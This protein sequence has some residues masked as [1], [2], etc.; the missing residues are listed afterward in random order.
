MDFSVPLATLAPITASFPDVTMPR[1]PAVEAFLQR[2]ITNE[3]Q[4][5]A[6]RAMH[7]FGRELKHRLNICRGPPGSGKSWVSCL[8]K[9]Y[10]LEKWAVFLATATKQCSRGSK[11]QEAARGVEDTFPLASTPSLPLQSPL[12]N[13]G[14]KWFVGYCITWALKITM[15]GS[16]KLPRTSGSRWYCKNS[17]QRTQQPRINEMLLRPTILIQSN[18]HD[19]MGCCFSQQSWCQFNS[20]ERTRLTSLRQC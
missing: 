15:A 9:L 2:D 12:P 3:D 17:P 20:C 7:R 6:F 4:R 19:S 8:I 1:Y 18:S 11:C 10:Y 14:F 16:E 5:N 13:S